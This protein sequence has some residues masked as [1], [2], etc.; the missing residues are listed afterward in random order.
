MI[1]KDRGLGRWLTYWVEKSNVQALQKTREWESYVTAVTGNLPQI[2]RGK[3]PDWQFHTNTHTIVY[4]Y[5]SSDTLCQS[6]CQNHETT[7]LKHQAK[8]LLIQWLQNI[9]NFLVSTPARVLAYSRHWRSEVNEWTHSWNSAPW[10]DYT[11]HPRLA[12]LLEGVGACS[13]AKEGHRE[14]KDWDDCITIP[15]SGIQNIVSWLLHL[16]ARSTQMTCVDTPG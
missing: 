5:H 16:H 15:H 9:I 14:I 4:L 2:Q 7:W 11:N 13:V 6:V 1:R 10:P 8:S 12:G 3:I